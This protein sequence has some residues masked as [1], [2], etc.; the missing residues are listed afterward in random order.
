MRAALELARRGRG[1]V[2][3]NPMV[4]AVIVRDG[5]EIARGFHRRVGGPHAEPEALRAAAESGEDVRGATVYCTLEP[6]CHTNKRTAPC[7]PAL[8]EAG[9]GRVVVAM[10][11]PDPNVSGRG[12]ELLRAA[13]IEVA[14][15]V[16]ETEARGLLAPYVKLRTQGRPWVICKWAQTRDGFLARPDG[17]GRWVS[18][19]ESRRAVH[20]LRGLCDAILVG[21]GT[22]FADDP[23]LTNRGDGPKR[24]ARIV[25]DSR[26]RTPPNS[27]LIRSASDGPVLIATTR[28]AASHEVGRVD[29]LFHA[30]AE[31]IE[32]PHAGEAL[33]L[34]ALLDE[35]GRRDWTY[36]LVEGGPRVLRSFVSG[37]LT[38]ELF[39]FTAPD[40]VGGAAADGDKGE[41]LPRF[42]I[43]D[44]L[45]ERAWRLIEERPS[46]ADT[47]RR[48]RVR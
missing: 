6:C 12:I 48:Y 15:G 28:F 23:L 13:G 37:G 44:V 24:P 35:L 11:D 2:E 10:E 33:D 17:Q 45:G 46:G 38:D 25:L 32:L 7:V 16:C 34:G 43:A 47:L 19:A 30:G 4:G 18:G 39:V 14:V 36:L 22:V 8:I 31:I 40:S 29:P 9:V 26:L 21:I 27:R 41:N 42:D 1:A 5:R 20:E 3:P